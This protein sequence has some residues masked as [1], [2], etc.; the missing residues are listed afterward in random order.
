MDNYNATDYLRAIDDLSTAIDRAMDARDLLMQYTSSL[1][2]K[3]ESAQATLL[4]VIPG[5][6]EGLYFDVRGGRA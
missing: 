4:T 6:R 2:S 5:R 1:L 3:D